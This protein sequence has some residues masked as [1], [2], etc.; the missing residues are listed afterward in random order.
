MIGDEGRELESKHRNYEFLEKIYSLFSED[1]YFWLKKPEY[2]EF[3][4][5]GENG[6]EPDIQFE[7]A[8]GECFWI[9]CIYRSDLNS[10]EELILYDDET[11]FERMRDYDSIGEP[12]FIAAGVGG[13]PDMPNMFLFENIF[14]FAF[15]TIN[16]NRC[17]ELECRMR[18]EELERRIA[19]FV[20]LG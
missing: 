9:D 13:S 10:E 4:V 7:S 19:E 8:A 11:Y 6:Y 2:A 14:E 16:K 18:P 12:I 20:D 5:R 15:H 17:Y 1:K 3:K